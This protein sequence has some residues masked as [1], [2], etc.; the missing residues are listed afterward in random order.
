MVNRAPKVIYED[1][2]MLVV[3]KPAGIVVNRAETVKEGTVQDWV[4]KSFQ[5][6]VF[7][8]QNLRSGIVHRL[9]KDTSGVLVMGKTALACELLKRQFKD[10]RV[11]KEYLALV[12]GRVEPKSGT[13]AV[14]VGRSRRNRHK[15][16]V[17]T[18]GRPAETKYEVDSYW[19][20]KDGLNYTLLRL[21]PKTGRTHQLRVHLAYLGHPLVADGRYGGEKQARRDRQW[22]P[23][24]WLHA[25]EL[26]L[27]HPQGGAR[28][29]QSPL[30]Q[31]LAGALRRLQRM[32]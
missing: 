7:S 8:F 25:G 21:Q 28:Q 26:K 1:E 12:H 14:P 5:F 20:D 2:V 3:D 31:D 23:R 18:D 19:R 11:I 32:G 16:A 29:W 22:C 24:Q 10:R 17:K 27:T 9:D 6:P 30:P 13:I 4:E 15:F